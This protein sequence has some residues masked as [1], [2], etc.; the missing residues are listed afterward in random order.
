MTRHSVAGPRPVDLGDFTHRVVLVGESNPYGS[1]PQ[2]ALHPGPPGCSGHRLM[3]IV[4]LGEDDYLSIARVNL[5]DGRW[6]IRDARSRAVELW[7]EVL[8]RCG[9]DEPRP[10]VVM[11]GVKVAEAFSRVVT[12]DGTFRSIDPWDVLLAGDG[13]VTFV[14]LPHPSGLSRAWNAN[15]WGVGG[16]VERARGLLSCA[17]PHVQWGGPDWRG[18]HPSLFIDGMIAQLE[19]EA[20][21]RP[22]IDLTGE[23]PPEVV[24]MLSDA[25]AEE[26]PLE[27]HERA[28]N[29]AVSAAILGPDLRGAVG[30]ATAAS[31]SVAVRAATP[32]V[33]SISAEDQAILDR[34]ELDELRLLYDAAASWERVAG[35]SRADPLARGAADQA[36]LAAVAR[37]RRF[38]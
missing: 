6:S 29:D 7:S 23:I 30:A 32:A 26:W 16:T 17:A 20:R 33:L 36:L 13:A 2:Y 14:S 24:R 8:D 12:R 5:C 11:L 28:L 21:A 9:G 10:T 35:D 18:D 38:R 15:M 31:A 1:D 22:D 3:Q 25:G 34:R 19:C 37:C 27:D 4:G